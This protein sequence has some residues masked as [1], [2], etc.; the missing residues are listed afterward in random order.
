MDL[1]RGWWW[2]EGLQRSWSEWA[3]PLDAVDWVGTCLCA[4]AHVRRAPRWEIKRWKVKETKNPFALSAC[5]FFFR[6]VKAKSKRS[7]WSLWLGHGRENRCMYV[8]IVS[9]GPTLQ[10]ASPFVNFHALSFTFG[11][12]L[13]PICLSPLPYYENTK[14]CKHIYTSRVSE[15]GHSSTIVNK[16]NTKEISW[17]S[18]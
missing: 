11:L 4:D 2:W 8:M 10:N 5:F 7:Q 6:C 17:E 9:G 3:P 18:E 15:F 1:T 12:W 16:S 13:L 14:A